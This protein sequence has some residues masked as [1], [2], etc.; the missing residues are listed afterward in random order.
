MRNCVPIDASS[1]WLAPEPKST[2]NQREP[3]GACRCLFMGPARWPAGAGLFQP[4]ETADV[5][6]LLVDGIVKLTHIDAEG[7]EFVVDVKRP[8]ALLGGAFVIAKQPHA[9]MA[10]T[11]TSCRICWCAARDFLAALHNPALNAEISRLHSLEVVDLSKRIMV[12]GIKSSQGRLFHFLRSYCGSSDG[13]PE[14]MERRVQL[15]LKQNEIASFIGITPEHMSRV[16]RKLLKEGLVRR[17]NGW[18]FV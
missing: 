15:P 9:F 14:C 7:R 8:P 4:G 6:Y 16:L 11:S 17:H 2:T 10:V 1:D 13:Q 3:S 5:V 18:L 12:M